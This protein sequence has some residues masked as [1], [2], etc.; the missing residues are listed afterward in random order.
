MRITSSGSDARVHCS[1]GQVC[2][3]PTRV[4]SLLVCTPY[5]CAISQCVLLVCR[6]PSFVLT[7]LL[8]PTHP[9]HPPPHHTPHT[10]LYSEACIAT[11]ALIAQALAKGGIDGLLIE[12]ANSWEEASL[13]LQATE[14]ADETRRLPVVVSMEGALRDEDLVPQPQWA[15]GESFE[16]VLY[17][18]ALCLLSSRVSSRPLAIHHAQ[19]PRAQPPISP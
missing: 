13:A 4:Y 3:L 19:S 15:P 2:V 12:T 1:R 11:Y 5:L 9:H 6:C 14:A 7:P 16:R 18:P 17:S 10:A 8:I